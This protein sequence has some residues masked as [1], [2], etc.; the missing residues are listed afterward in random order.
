MRPHLEPKAMAKA[1]RAAL[2][3]RQ[4]AISHGTAL[5]IVAAQ[6][7]LSS[8][9]VLVAGDSA[10]ADDGVRFNQTCP[11][12][13][14]FDEAVAKEFYVDFL[15]FQVDWEHRFGENFPLYAQVSRAGLTLHLS[16]HSGD[17]TPG[18]TVFVRMSGVEAFQKEL[19]SKN[20]KYGKP[21]LEDEPWGLVMKVIDPFSNNI[22]F[23]QD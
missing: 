15:G 20:Y 3:E 11:I 6:H 9:N 22:R 1:L 13:R 4:I 16:G 8:W 10:A 18:S 23:C 17:A 5:E 21:G 2:Q 7:G 12:M 14:I 19:T